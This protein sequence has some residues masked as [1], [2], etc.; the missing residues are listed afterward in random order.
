[1]RSIRFAPAALIGVLA[2]AGCAQPPT[3]EVDA[4]KHALEE[5]RKAQAPQYAPDA[6]SAAQQAQD[7]LDAELDA[8][9]DR[10]VLL[11]SYGEALTRASAAAAA[12]DAAKEAAGTAMQKAKDDATQKMSDARAEVESVKRALAGAPRGKGTEADLASMKSDAGSAESRL[13]EMQAAFD[14][15][16]YLDAAA[17][18]DSVIAT[19]HNLEDEIKRAEEARHSGRRT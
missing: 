7:R 10:F 17:K 8:Q 1:M 14:S 5:A 18:A 9:R 4:A 16:N 3:H 13:Q 12:A 15:G 6:W 2:L 19:C 11:R